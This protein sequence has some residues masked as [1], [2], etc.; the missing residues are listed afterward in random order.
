LCAS[1]GLSGAEPPDRAQGVYFPSSCLS[2]R[3]FEAVVHYMQAAGLDLA[4]LHA[5]DPLGRLFWETENPIACGMG[6]AS[7]RTPIPSALAFLKERKIWAAAKV[8]VFQDSLLVRN[9]PG[10]GVMDSETG[11]LWADHK[12]LHWANPYDR[13]VWEYIVDLC[14]ELLD[15]GVDEIQ[16]DYVRFPSDGNMS[17]LDYP[18]VLED[19]SPAEC[20]GEFLAYARSRLK[21]VGAIISVDLFGMTAWKTGDFGV[22]QVLERISPHVDVI[23]PMLYPSHFPRNFLDL[24]NPGEYPY[25]VMS[26]S[27]EEM[28]G[29]TD[30]EIRPWIQGFWYSPEE[31]EAQFRGVADKGIRSWTVWHPSGRYAETFQALEMSLG[32]RF[33]EPVLYPPLEELRA[34]DDLVMPGRSEIVNFTCYGGGYTIL[35]LDES[36]GERYEYATIMGVAST[37]DES[38]VDRILRARGITLSTWA[39]RYTK[40]KHLVDL[41]VADLDADPRRMCAEPIYIDW[42]GEAVFSRT[43]P[44]EALALYES[45]SGGVGSPAV[46]TQRRGGR[47]GIR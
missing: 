15:L 19:T 3:S 14:L 1:P 38:I 27:L 8:D 2:G 18:I 47:S 28:R 35:S 24:E 36:S 25:K 43:V 34:R 22:G 40:D 4:V 44:E 20:I 11:E 39:S 45:H 9:F 41:I 26:A 32:R 12:G 46:D 21:P 29:R 17:T 42:E 33:P 5:K 37:L 16:F 23:C 13:R 10:M 7:G 30:K 31:I 6:A